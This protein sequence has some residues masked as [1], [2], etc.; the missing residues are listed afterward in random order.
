MSTRRLGL[1]GA[2]GFLV[3]ARVLGLPVLTGVIGAILAMLL[4]LVGWWAF[5]S[6]RRRPADGGFE[7]VRVEDD[8]SARELAADEREYLQA[9]H[10]PADA[11][12]SSTDTSRARRT[13]ARAATCAAPTCRGT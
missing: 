11:R 4:A 12:T 3:L 6:R 2:L 8:G 7:Y 9:E 10:H 5:R 1:L 13:A